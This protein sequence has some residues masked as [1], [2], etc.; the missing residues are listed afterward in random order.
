MLGVIQLTATYHRNKIHSVKLPPTLWLHNCTQIH[1]ELCTESDW[2][3]T[4]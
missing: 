4:W 1:R 3:Q 2:T